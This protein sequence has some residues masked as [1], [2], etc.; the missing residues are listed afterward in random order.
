[1]ARKHVASEEKQSAIFTLCKKNI[2][3]DKLQKNLK[4]LL[5][6]YGIL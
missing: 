3:W 6:Q 4:F 5:Q 1:M 2:K